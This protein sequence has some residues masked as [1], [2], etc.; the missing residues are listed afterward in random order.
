M[1]ELRKAQNGSR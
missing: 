1:T